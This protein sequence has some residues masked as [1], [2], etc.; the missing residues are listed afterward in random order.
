MNKPIF[1]N[2]KYGDK[3]V[4]MNHD[5]S[6][7][8]YEYLC[9]DPHWKEKYAFLLCQ[10]GSNTVH[11]NSFRIESEFLV[12]NSFEEVKKYAH[13]KRAEYCRNWLNKHHK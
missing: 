1:E 9:R 3:L 10:D 12:Y 2:L 8:L 4:K 6:Y 7:S 5:G 13:T 11:I